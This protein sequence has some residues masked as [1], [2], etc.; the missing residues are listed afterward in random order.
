MGRTG[1]EE[2]LSGATLVRPTFDLNVKPRLVDDHIRACLAGQRD[3]GFAVSGGY[4]LK[5]F[6]IQV[7]GDHLHQRWLVI[8]NKRA[9]ASGGGTRARLL[10]CH[11]A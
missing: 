3:R 5:A 9:R 4:H 2:V 10:A 11:A 7:A 8:D 1:G 6:P